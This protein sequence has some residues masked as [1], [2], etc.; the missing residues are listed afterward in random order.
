MTRGGARREVH[1]PEMLWPADFQV[2]Q[3][4]LHLDWILQVTRM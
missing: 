4:R 3:A 2:T 1:V